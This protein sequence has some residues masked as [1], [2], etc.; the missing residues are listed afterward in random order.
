MKKILTFVIF[1]LF[2][3]ALFVSRAQA[4]E[5]VTGYLFWGEGCPHCAKEKEF[6]ADVAPSYP[7]FS[8]K[9]FEIYNSRENAE[10][11]KKVSETL[12]AKVQGVP[13]LIIGDETITGYAE[14]VTSEQ[15]IHRIRDCTDRKC[16]DSVA[17]IVAGFNSDAAGSADDDPARH[18]TKRPS[19]NIALPVFG[20][21]N[22]ASVSLPA[23]TVIMG[24][25]D[26]FNPCAMWILFFLIG[27]LFDMKNRRRMWILGSVFI[28]ASA[29]VYF[30]FMAAW[31]NIIL[32]IGFLLWIRVAI[33]AVAIISGVLHLKEGMER[34]DPTCKVS[35]TGYRKNIFASIKTS[36]HQQS[37]I[38]ALAGIIALAFM[39]NLVELLCSAGLPAVYTQV[40]S[41]NKLPYWQ[42]YLYIATYIFFFM[43]DDLIVFIVSM[44]TLKV[45]GITN[46]YS[47][48][49]RL[50]GGILMLTLGL[51]LIFKPELLLFG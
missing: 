19:L 36:V 41:L 48:L 12:G 7:D 32:F 38:L 26:G 37:F 16:P 14:G 18:D 10:L 20:T 2:F 46:N 22:T 35:N 6:F 27:M 44:V 43:L 4:K 17:P 9:S 23:L 50:I 11:L 51:L 1:V 5:H 30:V 21:L 34:R 31:L 49:S 45:T 25:L 24:I 39:V 33:G 29:A 3:A 15:I 28:A 13:F 42:Y 8:L 47:R 40:L